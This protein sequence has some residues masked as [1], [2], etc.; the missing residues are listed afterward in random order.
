MKKLLSLFVALVL[1]LSNG[2][3]SL[4]QANDY[5]NSWAKN[6][7]DYMRAKGILS[8][9]P[10]GTFKPTNKMSKS[11][12]YR[13]I[14][15]LMGYTE[16]SENRFTDVS[17]TDWYYEEVQ[18]GLRAE[19]ILSE[20]VLNAKENIT[21]GEVARIISVVFGIEEDSSAAEVFI[22]NLRFTEELKGVIG[23]LKKNGFVNG[24]PDGTFRP[25]DE[26]TRAEVIKMIHNISGEIVNTSDIVSKDI[27]TNLLI[28]TSGVILK[29]MTI[30]GNLYLTEGIGVGDITLDNVIVK[31][32]LIIKGG[33]SNSVTIR[34]SKIKVVSV[35][36][37]KGLVG[38]KFENTLVEE[39]KAVN[40]V[41]LELIN[42]T[43]I[44]KMQLDGK[45]EIL[46]EEGGAI[47]ILRIS[48]K[49]VI[50]RSKGDI[51]SILGKQEIEINGK[52]V[53]ANV[54]FKVVEGKVLDV[55]ED[56]NIKPPSSGGSGGGTSNDHEKP[57]QK[58][59]EPAILT[60]IKISKAADKLVYEIG[61]KL[62][63]TGLEVTGIYSDGSKKI[64]EVKIGDISGFDSS[65]EVISQTL[66]ITIDGKT[67]TYTIKIKAK[68][69]EKPE[70]PINYEFVA[71]LDKKD[72]T[73]DEDITLS[74]RTLKN[75]IGINS[76][77]ITLKLVDDEENLIT[78]DQ[79]HTRTDGKLIY[80]FQVPE[81]TA[82]GVY[83]LTVK[84]GDPLSK[85]LKFDLVIKEK[86]EPAVTKD[87]LD[88]KLKEAEALDPKEYTEKSW[89]NLEAVISNAISIYC[90]NNAT[91]EEVNKAVEDLINAIGLLEKKSVEEIKITLDY[92]DGKAAYQTSY[93]STCFKIAKVVNAPKNSNY[94]KVII[95][96]KISTTGKITGYDPIL[97]IAV[98]EFETLLGTTNGVTVQLFEDAKAT[99]RV[100]EVQVSL[101]PNEKEPNEVTV[102][103]N[104]EEITAEVGEY[105]PYEGDIWVVTTGLEDDDIDSIVIRS[106]DEKIISVTQSP[107]HEIQDPKRKRC[108]GKAISPGEAKIIATVTT[109]DGKVYTGECKVT[110]TPP[111]VKV[112]G[113]T[114]NK[115]EI[116]LEIGA[117]ETLVATIDPTNAT[118]KNITWKSNNVDIATVDANGKV[119]AVALGEA[120]I[121]ATTIDG[122]KSATCV[123]TVTEKSQEA[124][125]TLNYSEIKIGMGEDYPKGKGAYLTA[126]IVGLEESE[127]KD[128][129]FT[130]SDETVATLVQRNI[131]TT[132]Y[133]KGLKNGTAIVTVT[134]TD[135]NDN[136]YIAGCKIIVGTGVEDKPL[137]PEKPDENIEIILTYY[138]G[139]WDYSG[140]PVGFS[141]EAIRLPND[142]TN[143]RVVFKDKISEIVNIEDIDTT[144]DISIDE[145]E[146]LLEIEKNVTVQ[147][148]KEDKTTILGEV[149]IIPIPYE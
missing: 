58:P 109:V 115:T 138:D 18:K 74:G 42:R 30:E 53:K 130:I 103:F 139:S 76:V 98:D 34:N 67:A 131:K 4:G 99:I 141:I 23:G 57:T 117:T 95:A 96:D 66:V 146:E 9:Y 61:E 48:N 78:L 118:N 85:A 134:V 122:N 27:K 25:Q 72:Y 148:F 10:D 63:I 104:I 65:K 59:E 142:E 81:E 125:V 20:A 45:G 1:I 120:V 112:I 77:D 51:Q 7:I 37:Q 110:V 101:V 13:V 129:K 31:G 149:Q 56:T 145:F 121:I 107:A 135:I 47:A 35:N 2:T 15:G 133:G 147:F 88:K 71:E 100:G 33:G 3:I 69:V 19:Y 79:I 84:A 21:R 132:S 22:D 68:E 49:N 82:G 16:K 52:K 36:R 62:D 64:K 50:V 119:T 140:M 105:F 113:I 92:Y 5:E 17:P 124:A 41:K 94:Y 43:K 137:E 32:E 39:L 54:E 73:V 89:E 75:N 126:K 128:I 136:K 38:I 114:L 46:V 116:P 28:N 26:I 91:Q 144:M 108:Y 14:N 86:E 12:F 44:N 106:S 90:K 93:P 97:D 8:G 70:E 11:E 111:V 60:G 127:I 123:V 6:E 29:D 80:T 143:Y 40:E 87:N 102:T 83:K 55:K 24:F